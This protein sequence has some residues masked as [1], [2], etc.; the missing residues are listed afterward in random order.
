MYIKMFLYNSIN[1]TNY[2][3]RNLR[4]IAKFHMKQLNEDELEYFLKSELTNVL[5][6]K[7]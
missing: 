1:Y 7:P 6:L 2:L 3:K 4:W 5:K